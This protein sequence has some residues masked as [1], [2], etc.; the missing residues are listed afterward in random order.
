MFASAALIGTEF[1]NIRRTAPTNVG[2][3]NA[4]TALLATATDRRK[5]TT[6]LMRVCL[7]SY[8]VA[9]PPANCCSPKHRLETIPVQAAD[10]Y[11]CI[12]RQI[13]DVCSAR[14]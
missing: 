14:S 10:L 7:V 12:D 8:R 2:T 5:N 1:V 13:F 11:S 4:N 9:P 6:L 3:M